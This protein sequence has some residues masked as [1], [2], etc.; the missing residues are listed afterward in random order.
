MPTK[1]LEL[2]EREKGEAVVIEIIGEFLGMDT[3]EAISRYFREHYGEWFP[4]CA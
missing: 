4:R 1:K 2:I 3:D